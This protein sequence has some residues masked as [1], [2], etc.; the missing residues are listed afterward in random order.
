MNSFA[1][2]IEDLDWPNIR[3]QL[4]QEGFAVLAGF[5]DPFEPLKH[6]WNDTLSRLKEG[7]Y[8]R[9]AQVSNQ[10]NES[11]QLA[12]RYPRQLADFQVQCLAAGQQQ[13]L[14]RLTCLREEQ[15][16]A[17]T[18]DAEGQYVFPFQLQA[19]LSSPG[20]DFTGGEFVLTEQRPRMQSRPMV[21]PLR[22]GDIAITATAHRPFKGS[23]GYYR[24][25][26]KRAISRVRSGER[27]GFSLSFHYGPQAHHD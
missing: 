5:I 10:W 26:M 8:P 4:D 22:P 1:T 20:R 12:Y 6:G 18:Q 15:Y 24:V 11:L 13:E 16:L 7:F 19:V 21:V 23:K 14:S 17:L 25:N 2:A 3:L 9:L 27:L